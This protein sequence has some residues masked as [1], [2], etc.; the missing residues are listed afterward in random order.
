MQSSNHCRFGDAAN[1]ALIERRSCSDPRRM[2]IETCFAKKVAWFQDSYDR[3]LAPL[4]NDRELD[5]AALDVK[6]RVRNV[7]LAENNLALLIFRYCFSISAKELMWMVRRTPRASHF[8][9]Q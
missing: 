9:T 4:R 5:L 1:Q 7:T 8:I 6:D 3:F 2:A